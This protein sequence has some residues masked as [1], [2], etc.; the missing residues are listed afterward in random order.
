MKV[1]LITPGAAPQ[2]LEIEHSLKNMQEL[3]GGTIEAIYPFE[4]TVALVCN[5]EGKLLGLPLNRTVRDPA[6][7]QIVDII[8]GTFFI[9]G[10]SE[11]DFASLTDDQIQ[12][13]TQMF[14]HPEVFIQSD[15]QIVI[16]QME[17]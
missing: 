12:R 2:V 9:C 17:E 7:G 15:S 3:V 16:L 4:D 14:R 11:D 6:T 1:L 8:A 5:D 13:Y 10:L